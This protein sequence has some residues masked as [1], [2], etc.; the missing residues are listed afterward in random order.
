MQEETS[1]V[2]GQ[3]ANWL[4]RHL[5]QRQHSDRML[6]PR[7]SSHEATAL[8]INPRQTEHPPDP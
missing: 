8:L 5:R 2:W 6:S 4:I 3:L 1:R 7:N